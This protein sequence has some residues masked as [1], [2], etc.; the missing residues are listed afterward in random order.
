MSGVTPAG[1]H[2]GDAEKTGRVLYFDNNS[3]PALD[4][5]IGARGSLPEDIRQDLGL[6]QSRFQDY[7][8]NH[9]QKAYADYN[10]FEL[11]AVLI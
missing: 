1:R 10:R 5:T 3:I 4:R 6:W 7:A 2:F 8:S 11:D 9:G